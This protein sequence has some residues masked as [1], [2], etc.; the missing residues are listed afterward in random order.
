MSE[1]CLACGARNTLGLQV[2]LAFDDEGVWARFQ[3]RAPWGTPTGCLHPATAPVILDEV[4]WWLGALVMKE[5]GV[6]NRLSV[7]FQRPDTPFSEPLV[8]SGRFEDVKPVD[9]R[10]TFWRIACALLTQSG[11]VLA[12]A[13][14]VF[15]GGVE[16]SDRQM[17][18][19]RERTPAE[20]FRRMF[21]AHAR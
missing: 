16:Y 6:T 4:A 19:F 7:T 21:P 13:S 8:A 1:D 14:I 15:R 5:G 12:S 18:Y 11:H 3:P 9:R 2:A 17:P 20:V 10:R